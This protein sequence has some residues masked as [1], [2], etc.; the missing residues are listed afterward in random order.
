MPLKMITKFL[1]GINANTRPAEIAAGIAFGFLLALQPGMTAARLVLLALA[2]MLKINMPALFLSLFL[3]ALGA[4][5]LDA[6]SGMIGGYILGLAPLRGIFTTM[7]NMPLVPYTRFNDT[8]VMGGLALGL[9]AWLPVFFMCIG[10]VK[11]YRNTLREKI[12]NNPAFKAFLK[13]PLVKTIAG[14]VQ[15]VLSLTGSI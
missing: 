1:A 15:K 14:I 3:F 9:A 13:L 11:A 4:P 2:F 10:L 8:L 12:V 6:P 7:Y 5:L